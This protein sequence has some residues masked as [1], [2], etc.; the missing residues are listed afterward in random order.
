MAAHINTVASQLP[1]RTTAGYNVAKHALYQL[2]KR[3][4]Y[5]SLSYSAWA[6]FRMGMS[7]SASFQRVRKSFRRRAARPSANLVN[8]RDDASAGKCGLE[9]LPGVRLLLPYLKTEELP[10][11]GNRSSASNEN[12]RPSP[13]NQGSHSVSEAACKIS[14][15]PRSPH[16]VLGQS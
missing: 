8:T 6:C 14:R 16:L 3:Q 9:A 13:G 5:F 7:G 4:H 1:S 12:V 15:A 10:V 2:Q 11:F